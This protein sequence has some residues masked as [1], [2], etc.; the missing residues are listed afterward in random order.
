MWRGGAGERHPAVTGGRL[1]LLASYLRRLF[2]AVTAITGACCR[3]CVMC[4]GESAPSSSS[5]PRW[6]AGHASSSSAS[7]RRPA[8]TPSAAPRAA[9]AAEAVAAVFC[10]LGGLREGEAHRQLWCT[11]EVGACLCLCSC[12]P[13]ALDGDGLQGRDCFVCVVS[14]LRVAC[15]PGPCYRESVAI[16]SSLM[17]LARCLEVLRYNQQHPGDQKV[18]P[19][20]E[21]KVGVLLLLLAGM[22]SDN[23]LCEVWYS[24][25]G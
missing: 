3:V 11:L 15:V 18:I 2:A 21:S 23:C 6:G 16:N 5:H 19:Y 7:N 10:G 24:H 22:R 1:C 12:V 17:T 13:L 8:D 14:P 9:A 20:R 4:A 25:I